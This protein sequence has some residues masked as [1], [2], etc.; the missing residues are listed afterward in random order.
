[1]ANEMDTVI[2]VILDARRVLPCLRFTYRVSHPLSF[3]PP[4]S[5]FTSPPR[6]PAC[7][8]KCLEYLGSHFRII[9]ELPARLTDLEVRGGGLTLR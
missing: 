5:H 4:F 9:L 1:M 8:V 3:A 7:R 6:P 2:R